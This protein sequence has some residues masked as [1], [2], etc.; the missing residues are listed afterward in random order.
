MGALA[1]FPGLNPPA[2]A[3]AATTTTTEDEEKKG[4]PWWVWL[5]VAMVALGIVAAVAAK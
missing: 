4:T 3:S 1:N 2:S 5:I